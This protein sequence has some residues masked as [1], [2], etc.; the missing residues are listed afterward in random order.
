MSK[1]G[2]SSGSVQATYSESMGFKVSQE[3]L[4]ESEGWQARS[5][6]MWLWRP[7]YMTESSR[8]KVW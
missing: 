6:K 1:E 4:V 7:C 3:W 8:Q 2:T 5:Q